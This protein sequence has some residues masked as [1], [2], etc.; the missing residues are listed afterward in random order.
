MCVP[1]YRLCLERQDGA[2]SSFTAKLLDMRRGS[3]QRMATDGVC[4][5]ALYMHLLAVRV[6]LLGEAQEVEG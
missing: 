6:L 3:F 5:P 4:E 1:P 2:H